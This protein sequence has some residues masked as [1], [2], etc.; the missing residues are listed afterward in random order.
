MPVSNHCNSNAEKKVVKIFADGVFDLMHSGHFNAVRQ[1][2][3]LGD[4]L[5]VGINSD[6]EVKRAKGSFPIYSQNERGEIMRGCKWVDEVIVGTPYAVTLE[7]LNSTG[8]DFVAHGD[9]HVACADGTDCYEEPR[10][11]GRLKTFQ[12]TVGISTT[13]LIT[14]LLVATRWIEATSETAALLK[15]LTGHDEFFTAAFDFVE[16]LGTVYTTSQGPEARRPDCLRGRIIRHLPCWPFE[17][18]CESESDGRLPRGWN[19]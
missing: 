19:S 5:V 9:D 18:P 7:F 13:T 14:R 8:C 2:R 12:R 16:A 1:A 6:T 15:S 10:R 11:A 4:Y 17:N 3:E